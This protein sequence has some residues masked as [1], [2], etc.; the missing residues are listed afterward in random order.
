MTPRQQQIL[1]AI[2]ELYAKTAEPV[3][4][5]ALTEQVEYSSAT[6]RAEMAALETGGYIMQPHISAGRVPTDKGYRTYVNGLD[7]PHDDGRISQAIM[8]RVASAGH[9]DSMIRQAAESLSHATNNVGLATL[10]H[11]LFY[12]G[13]ANLFSQPEFFG[14]REAYE[15]ARLLDNLDEWAREAAAHGNRVSVFIGH[16]NPIGKASGCTLIIGRF[17]SPFSD[18]SYIGVLG[19]TRQDYHHAI[20]MVGYIS[21]QLEEVL[22]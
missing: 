15:A 9:I 17:S 6:I 10:S 8:K 18:R 5:L 1:H 2:V 13:L 22:A 11:Q 21:E 16:E 4:S 14:R 19:P 7:T 20:G 3:G 12:T